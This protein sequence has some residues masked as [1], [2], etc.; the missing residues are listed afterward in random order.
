MDCDAVDVVVVFHP[1][2][3]RR[4]DLDNMLSRL[5]QGCDAVADAIE[6]DDGKWR[7]MTLERGDVMPGG[8]VWIYVQPSATPC[9]DE[10]HRA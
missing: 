10:F 5:K 9:H 1:P 4:W 8:G 2:S 7:S 6:V 3:R